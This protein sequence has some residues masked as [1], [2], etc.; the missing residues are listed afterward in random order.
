M[1]G[2]HDVTH[3][4]SQSMH[5]SADENIRHAP[6]I[7]QALEEHLQKVQAEIKLPVLYL[8]DS[9]LKNVGDVYTSLFTQN[10]VSAFCGVFEKGDKETRSQMF[11]LRKTWKKVSPPEKLHAVDVRVNA[12][13]PAWPI[14]D[15]PPT[16][17]VN[18]RVFSSLAETTS[19]SCW[20]GSC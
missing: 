18:P 17:D 19:A 7:V 1:A 10:F 16:I 13:D 15:V 11:T 2:S 8:I 3:Y 6:I 14:T 5:G 4:A 12:V 20:A 9:I